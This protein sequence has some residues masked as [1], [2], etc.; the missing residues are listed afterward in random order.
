M[1]ITLIKTLKGDFKI[2]YNSDYETAKKIPVND[3]IEYE[4][5]K[6]R[7][8]K[9][10]KKFFALVNLV[11]N[12]QEIYNNIE[13]LRKELIISAGHYELIFDL[14]TGEQK[15]EALSIKFS[16][17]DEIEFNKVY[18]DV[19]NVIVNKF[20]FDKQDII[21]NIEQYF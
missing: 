13:H 14:E 4:F 15:K 5:K 11:F 7:N 9:F 1:K 3:P 10:H 16:S 19:L 2:A 6:V 18:S 12:N 8:Y 21:D 17:M 20:K